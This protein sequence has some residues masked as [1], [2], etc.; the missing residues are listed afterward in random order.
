MLKRRIIWKKSSD[1]FHPFV[2]NF[3]GERCV[4]RLNDFPAE[5]LYTLIVDGEEVSDFD[6]WSEHW[7]RPSQT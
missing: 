1:P 5:H 4:I 7:L 3:E 6:D 2:A